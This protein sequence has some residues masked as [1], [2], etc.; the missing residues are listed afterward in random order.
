MFRPESGFPPR[1]KSLAGFRTAAGFSLIELLCVCVIIS[2]LMSLLLPTLFRAYN[3]V[4]GVSEDWDAKPVIE[5]LLRGSRSYCAAN[6]HY[7]FVS[8]SDFA[9]KCRLAPKPRDWLQAAAT[10]FVPF[11]YLDSTNK[12]VLTFHV[13]QNHKSYYAF[14]VGDLSLRP[15]PR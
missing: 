13:G 15:P 11:G 5:M 12:I 6:P 8:R 14:N 7:Y 2:I 3:R 10:E 4:K 9:D 1:F